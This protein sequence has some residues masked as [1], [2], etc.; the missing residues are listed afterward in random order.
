MRIVRT[1][2]LSLV[3]AMLSTADLAARDL[4]VTIQ[5]PQ[6]SL[7]YESI[8]AFKDRVE[9]ETNG[10]LSF[11]LF[12]NSQLYKAQE[13]KSA[14]GSGTIEMGASLLTEYS[15]VVPAAHIFS[16]PFLFT[17]KSVAAKASAIGSAVRDPIDNGIRVA[18]GARVLWWVPST[19]EVI[20]A[21][22]RAYRRPNDIT[23]R[24]IRVFGLAL[25]ELIRLCGG[26]PVVVPGTEQYEFYKTG[27]VAGGITTIDVV[28]SRRL[29]EVANTV[30]V[31][32][33]IHEVWVILMSE[34]VWRS[35]REGE[36]GIVLR[37]AQE[38][39]AFAR[40]KIEEL[41]ARSLEQAAS[42]GMKIATLTDAEIEEWKTCSSAIGE[43][44]LNKAGAQGELVMTGYRAILAGDSQN[45]AP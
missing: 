26:E 21:K 4:K 12:A 24:K 37:A 28:I 29:W 15:E 17:N 33:Q 23:G 1:S 16:L 7:L 38:A 22:D 5:M 11:T 30:V 36:R 35:L 18:T 44:F 31:A 10:S 40:E 25:P 9:R 42:H 20:I 27:R 13:V 19:A 45:P 41:E 14:V 32:R 2:M 34:N 6:E 3:L 39:E 8:R 43:E